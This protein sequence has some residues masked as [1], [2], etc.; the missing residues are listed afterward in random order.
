[1]DVRAA[2]VQSQNMQWV[3]ISKQITKLPISAASRQKYFW[4]QLNFWTQ[5]IRLDEGNTGAENMQ[6]K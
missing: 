4:S 5:F 3:I 2:A 1:M 6:K